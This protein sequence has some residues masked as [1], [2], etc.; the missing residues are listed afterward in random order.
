MDDF[1][2]AGKSDLAWAV[3]ATP[4]QS[5]KT[6]NIFFMD[7]MGVQYNHQVQP[8]DHQHVDQPTGIHSCCYK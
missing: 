5:A 1:G 8:V 7:I 6:I 4:K 2:G 3:D